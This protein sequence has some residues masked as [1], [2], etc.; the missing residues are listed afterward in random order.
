MT[1]VLIDVRPRSY[2]AVIGAGALGDFG[3][4]IESALARK[5]SKVFV[6]TVPPVKKNCSA[7]LVSILKDKKLDC[8]ILEFGDGESNKTMRTAEALASRLVKAGAD[9][10]SLLIGL[11]GGV[12]GDVAGFVAS[13]Y[14]RGIDLIQ[15]PTTFLAQVDAAIGGKTGV[16]LAAGKNLI[17]TF[18]HPRLVL[19]DP[20]LLSTLP[21]REFRSGLYEALKCGVIQ[22]PKIFEFMEQKREQIL[23]RD[24]ESLEWL[25]SECVRVKAKVVAADEFEAGE[26]RILN[27]G[28]TL[29]HALE[30]ETSY[31]HFLHGEAVAWGMVGA[32]M[33]AAAMQKSDGETARRIIGTVLAYAPLPKVQSRSKNVI[34]RLRSDKKTRNGHVH[35]VLP[36]Q[37]GEVEI[38]SDVPDRAVQQAVEE[39]RYL[40][41]L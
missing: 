29:G 14:M 36:R 13:I 21:E 7:L 39:I 20:E 25:I 16:N 19:V 38:V 17:G 12:A 8:E 18:H 6:I 32:A 27:F 23:S 30:A 9:R 22:D 33:I 1:R 5:P 40:S 28:H 41:Q 2:E 35:F 31:K 37:I 34:K 11:G 15:I 3:D 24:P 4:E 10:H 26:R